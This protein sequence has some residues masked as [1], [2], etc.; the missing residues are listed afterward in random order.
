MEDLGVTVKAV[1]GFSDERGALIEAISDSELRSGALC[2]LHMVSTQ[3]GTAR[4]NHVHWARTETIVLIEGRF[5]VRMKHVESGREAELSPSSDEHLS[6]TIP[7]GVAHAFE[8]VGNSVGVL[9]CVADT[10]FD[11]ADIV[12][13]PLL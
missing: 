8:N 9:L 7:P 10:P 4:G 12:R 11:E 1:G 6:F 2:N 5:R 13:Y 3:P